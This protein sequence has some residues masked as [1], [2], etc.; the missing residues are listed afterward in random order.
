MPRVRK[1]ILDRI[2]Y[3]DHAIALVER[4][5]MRPPRPTLEDVRQYLS[6]APFANWADQARRFAVAETLE[7]KIT[8]RT[9]VRCSIR[10]G[11]FATAG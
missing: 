2:D 4:E 11:F 1:I 5:H 3:I 9:C 10:D 8:S 7:R 6:G